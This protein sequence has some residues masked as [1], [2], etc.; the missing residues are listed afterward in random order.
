MN[1]QP[2]LPQFV[3]LVPMRH[4]SERVPGK[5]YRPLVGRPLYEYILETLHR[6][7][8]IEFIVVDTDSPVIREGVSQAFPT[9]RLLDRPEKLRGGHVSMNEVLLHDVREVESRYYLQTHSTNPLLQPESIQRAI[10][11][12]LDGL[13]D[14]DTLFAVTAW[15]TR[16]WNA[17]AEPI[18]HDPHELLRTQDLSPIF[19]EN[20]CIYIFDRDGFLARGNRIG[21]RPLMFEL[22]RREGLDIDNEFAFQLAAALLDSGATS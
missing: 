22:S 10:Q 6:V 13:P 8:Q 3:A 5:N 21:E 16:F 1:D 7:P 15:R 9:V 12:F 17:Q 20:S 2:E 18:N 11:A 4:E 14:H 19:E